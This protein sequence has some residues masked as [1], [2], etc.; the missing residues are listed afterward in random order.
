MNCPGGLF[1]GCGSD[2]DFGGGG[3]RGGRNGKHGKGKKREVVCLCNDVSRET[4]EKAIK[5]G[6]DTLNKIF[7]DTRAGV[8]PCGG[9]CRRKLGP[10]LDHYQATGEFPEV[11]TIDKTGKK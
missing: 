10:L 2:D 4:I 11:L 6:A 3:N 1:D 5:N 7:D 8:G 9:S